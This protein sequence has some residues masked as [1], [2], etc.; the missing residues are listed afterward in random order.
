MASL[1]S[2][3]VAA[4]YVKI[5]ITDS[6]TGLSGT[7]TNI[8]DGDGTASP[9]YLSTSRLGIGNASPATELDVTGA[10]TIST[11]SAL[12][13][14]VSI[15]GGY[16]S[17]GITLSDAGVIQANGTI[18]ID[19]AST[20]T[21]A[22][23]ASSTAAIAGTTTIGGGYGSTGV[24]LTDAG[25]VQM[26]GALTVDGA[27]T[28]AAISC[29]A[30]TTSGTLDYNNG[31]IDL[32]TQTVDVSLN[33]AVDALN[34]DSNTLSIDASNNRIGIGTAAPDY[35]LHVKS[36]SADSHVLIESTES[37]TSS[38]PDIEF[39]RNP[40][41]AGATNDYLGILRFTGYDAA[42][43][44]LSFG[45][46]YCLISDATNGGEDGYMSM[47][48]L[49][50]GSMHNSLNIRAGLVGIGAT[51]PTENLHIY[52]DGITELLIESTDE[53]SIL[54]IEAGAVGKD[55][56]IQFNA[57]GDASAASI[58]YD[59]HGTPATQK[60]QFKVG[61]NA[62]TAA[63]ILGDGKIGIGLA[64]PGA[65]LHIEGTTGNVASKMIIGAS[66]DAFIT[67]GM[68]V[69]D[70]N[71]AYIAVDQSD[72]LAFGEML[73]DHD[74]ALENEWMRIT[75]SGNVGI[76]S[77]KPIY[78]LHVSAASGGELAIG[79][80]GDGTITHDEMLGHIYFAGTTDSGTNWDVGA[81]I[82]CAAAENWTVGS[83][84]GGDLL[85]YTVD[86]TTSVMDERMRILDNGRVGIGTAGPQ[87]KLDILGNSD[88]VAALKIGPANTT[89]GWMIYDRSTEGDLHIKRRVSDTE[90]IVM[91]LDR[92]SGNVG[93]GTTSPNSQLHVVQIETT[94]NALNVYRDK[95]SGSTSAPMVSFNN[96]NTG[97][98]QNCVDINNDG[99]GDALTISNDGSEIMVVGYAGAGN[100][101]IGTTGPLSKL[102]I[103]NTDDFVT[104]GVHVLAVEDSHSTVDAGDVLARFDYSQDANVHGDLAKFISFHDNG[105][106]IGYIATS[107]DGVISSSILS[108]IRLKDD[109]KDTSLDGLGIINA[110]K[111]RDFKWGDKANHN[112]IGNQVIGGFVADEVHEV[113][114]KAVHGKPGQMKPV[115]DEEGNK[116]GEEMN[117]MGVS[118]GEFISVLI[119]AVQELAAEIEALKNNNQ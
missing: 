114:P 3:T 51:N 113:Y 94:G 107:S 14:T 8:E 13:G 98:D 84:A 45:D 95:A 56:I 6:N 86:N 29:A 76:G 103:I 108:D 88:S 43:D 30:I 39:R 60:M 80:D 5:L 96:T 59:H 82:A 46:I 109:I 68:G 18:T 64:N 50:N 24:T 112:Q 110:L 47:R 97:D 54:D 20:L 65:A 21:G 93:I 22:V 92:S 89:H 44:R 90:T 106:E 1:T 11:T 41:E 12:A 61:D 73:N 36:T 19:G 9:L 52:A 42:S 48:T 71:T 35:T 119:K 116:I 91:A 58:I 67:V 26:N 28:L 17:T 4:S 72:G 85:F 40:G 117:P 49:V 101:G 70:S 31:T 102:H 27:S 55:S 63:T 79:R 81:G 62:T 111:I 115:K 34:F 16:G 118:S 69:P 33:A 25:V 74:V 75:N 32:S 77:N 57:N 23:T 99:S 87:A 100:V 104:S 66:N 2:Q 78:E 83:A 53:D 38:A 105:G 15:G 37:G 10:L 7:A